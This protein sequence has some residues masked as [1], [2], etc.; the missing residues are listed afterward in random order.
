LSNILPS[1]GATQDTDRVAQEAKK[2]KDQA[3]ELKSQERHWKEEKGTLE[4]SRKQLMEKNEVADQRISQLTSSNQELQNR[5]KAKELR[6]SARD[7]AVLSARVQK[8]ENALE[9]AQKHSQKLTGIILKE[10]N[11]KGRA[12]PDGTVTGKFVTLNQQ[13]Q[14]I[15][16]RYFELDPEI[17]PQALPSGN[18]SP[19][20]GYFY[21]LWDAD[22]TDDDLQNRARE[23]IFRIVWQQL[24]HTPCFGF[25]SPGDEDMESTSAQFEKTAYNN[26]H[27]KQLCIVLVV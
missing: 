10:S 9:E 25:T 21:D 22:Y 12:V 14:R 4:S 23:V 26:A 16:K 19:L 5:L 3:L 18:S 7:T 17:L 6:G 8:L 20:Q 13:I 11:E 15:V 24:L 27:G 1:F 2:W